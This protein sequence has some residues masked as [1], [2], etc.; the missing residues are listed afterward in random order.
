MNVVQLQSSN[1]RDVPATLRKIADSIESGDFG[2]VHD[3]CLILDADSIDVF[4]AGGG[5]VSD[6]IMLMNCGIAKLTSTILCAKG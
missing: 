2:D 4:H 5:D 1:F 3:A 6:A